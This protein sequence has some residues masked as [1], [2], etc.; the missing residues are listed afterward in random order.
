MARTPAYS[1]D[2]TGDPSGRF[3]SVPPVLFY[4]LFCLTFGALRLLLSA[5]METCYEKKRHTFPPIPS[6]WNWRTTD[7]ARSAALSLGTIAA[8]R[9]GLP[10]PESTDQLVMAPWNATWNG[11]SKSHHRP[12]MPLRG[13]GRTS[14]HTRGGR[15][16]LRFT[17]PT[18]RTARSPRTR[19]PCRA[20]E[21]RPP[22]KGHGRR[23]KPDGVSVFYMQQSLQADDAPARYRG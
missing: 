5:L 10:Y 7:E 12:V 21:C 14:A 22:M 11:A 1:S 23:L 16:D 20:T 4:H 17:P 9:K 3:I 8:I 15:L 13:G 19:L 6:S 2:K 18:P